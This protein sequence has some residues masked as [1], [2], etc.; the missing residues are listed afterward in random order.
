MGSGSPLVNQLGTCAV[1]GPVLDEIWVF[2]L[3]NLPLSRID[4]RVAL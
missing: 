4:D 2:C 1:K 3:V